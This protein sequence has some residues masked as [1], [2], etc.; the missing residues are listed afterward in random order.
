MI[1]WRKHFN[2]IVFYNISNYM[3][4]TSNNI[5]SFLLEMLQMR[6]LIRSTIGLTSVL[7]VWVYRGKF[8][9]SSTESI[10]LPVDLI[11]PIPIDLAI[12][13]F[14]QMSYYYTI[15]RFTY[16]AK[17]I[18]KYFFIYSFWYWNFIASYLEA[19]FSANQPSCLWPGFSNVHCWSITS[20][21]SRSPSTWANYHHSLWMLDWVPHI[22]LNL[23]LIF[24]V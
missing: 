15:V 21:N 23:F 18:K 20:N 17:T 5:T 7:V 10:L 8:L 14:F 24:F 19:N 13:Y 16:E 12:I 6:V 1:F 9:D 3:K 4:C 2:G 22:R 11:K